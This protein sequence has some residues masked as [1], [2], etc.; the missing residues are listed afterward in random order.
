MLIP[1]FFFSK[2]CYESGVGCTENCINVNYY[3][4]LAEFRCFDVKR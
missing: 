3:Y 1:I 4:S 2:F